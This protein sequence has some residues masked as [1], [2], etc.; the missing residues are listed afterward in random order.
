[1]KALLFVIALLIPTTASAQI[2]EPMPV[3]C[4][5]ATLAPPLYRDIINHGATHTRQD[6]N[7][8]LSDGRRIVV[9]IINGWSPSVTITDYEN[10]A[11]RHVFDYSKRRAWSG[12]TNWRKVEPHT[13]NTQQTPAVEPVPRRTNDLQPIPP[14]VGPR[15]QPSDEVLPT[16][17]KE[18]S[19]FLRRPSD[20][21][22]P[23]PYKEPSPFLR[24]PSDVQTSPDR[25]VP[26]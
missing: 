5:P 6:V 7:V 4:A 21:V 1:M 23:T 25:I 3:Y 20:E 15:I 19:P 14:R 26:R 8:T 24:R 17:Y 22:L 9:P 2:C 12:N 13:A 16:P 18:P 10:G 11:E